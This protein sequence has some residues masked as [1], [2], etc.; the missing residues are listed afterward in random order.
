MHGNLYL[1]QRR[2]CK[3]RVMK[4]LF[5][6]QNK[7]KL[8]ELSSMIGNQHQLL[9]LKDFDFDNE[10]PET[11][12]TLEDNA[13]EKANFIYSKLHI[14]CFS[15]DS[16]L[17]IDVLDNRPGVFSARYAGEEKD[18]EKNI[19]KVLEEMMDQTNRGA[20]FR[21]VIAMILDGKSFLF[22][23]IVRGKIL[24]HRKGNG[25]FGYDPVF[26]PDGFE[27]SFAEMGL[28]AKNKISHRAKAFEKLKAFL[29]SEFIQQ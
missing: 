8:M 15:E 7:N 21:T 11:H 2:N 24:Q 10:L 1:L 13:L 5:A 20:Q 16:G 23:G 4:I 29:E 19:D 6:T 12:F 14:N 22:E 26:V 28:E 27:T 17:E 25:G 9:S 3:T 18:D